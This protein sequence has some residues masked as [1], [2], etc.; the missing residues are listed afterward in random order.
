ME[1]KPLFEQGPFWSVWRGTNRKENVFSFPKLGYSSPRD[2]EH[3]RSSN[4]Q[5]LHIVLL[6]DGFCFPPPS[7]LHRGPLCRQLPQLPKQAQCS[8]WLFK[9]SNKFMLLKR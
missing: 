4:I 1:K 9:D 2:K 6:K 7:Q 5:I 8:N 3:F